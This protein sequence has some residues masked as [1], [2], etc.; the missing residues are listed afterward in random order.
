ML[1]LISIF[2]RSESEV[3]QPDLDEEECVSFNLDIN[4]TCN[5]E[6]KIEHVEQNIHI[7]ESNT[8]DCSTEI[9]EQT[10]KK[11]SQPGLLS[12]AAQTLT[13]VAGF[14][15][16]LLLIPSSHEKPY[17]FGTHMPMGPYPY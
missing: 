1:V 12:R 16:T 13:I 4:V 11:S 5:P 15:A 8:P 6:Q 2:L 9:K 14:A 10:T 3:V 7:R 17:V